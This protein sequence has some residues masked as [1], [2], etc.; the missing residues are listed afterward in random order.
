[1]ALLER[2]RF[3]GD[4]AMLSHITLRRGCDVPTH[5]HDNEQFACILSGRLRFGIGAEGSPERRNV[6]VSAGEV[7]HLPSGVPH[8]AY[9]EEDTVVL[10]VFSPPS[11]TTGIDRPAASS[12]S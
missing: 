3:I 4:K 5:A 9:A 11:Q 7:I 6:V 1:M 10:D 8:S 2:R 12:R